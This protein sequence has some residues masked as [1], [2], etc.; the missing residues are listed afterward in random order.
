MSYCVFFDF[1]SGLSEPLSVPKG[2]S[3]ECI[4]HVNEVESSL[5]IERITYLDNPPYWNTRGIALDIKDGL[6]CKT[7]MTHNQWV[8]GAYEKFQFWSENPFTIG[9]GHQGKWPNTGYPIGWEP[10]Q[11]TPETAQQF[12][13]GLSII[14]VPVERW[15]AEYYID[16][17]E[18]IYEVMRGRPSRGVS[19]DVKALT[20]KQAAQV[21]NLF[22]T[23]LD[24]EDRR[25]DVPNG[26]DYLASSY[27][28]G[29]DWCEKCG[30]VTPDDGTACTKRKC[31]I[32][33]ERE[34]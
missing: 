21:V 31:P 26:H 16:Q 30:A 14:D 33:M 3:Q 4:D 18:H 29:Y 13:P 22:S 23:F 24:Q 7:A 10:E 32:R 11:L 27:D 17:M 19:F 5:K 1:S 20:V 9:K 6:F 15:T 12:W 2:F 8:R 25:L 28:G 34:V